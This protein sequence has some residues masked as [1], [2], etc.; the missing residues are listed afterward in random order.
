MRL[1]DP[2]SGDVIRFSVY[3]IN[4]PVYHYCRVVREI[5]TRLNVD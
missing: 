2:I 3:L 5:Y 1:R 4:E